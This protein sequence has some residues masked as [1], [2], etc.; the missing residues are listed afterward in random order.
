MP[1]TRPSPIPPILLSCGTLHH[2]QHSAL[3]GKR[4]DMQERDWVLPSQ[5]AYDGNR[6]WSLPNNLSTNIEQPVKQNEQLFD[7]NNNAKRQKSRSRYLC[8]AP[9]FKPMTTSEACAENSDHQHSLVLCAY[10]H[11]AKTTQPPAS[12]SMLQTPETAPSSSNIE[13]IFDAALKSYNKKTKKDIK[14]HD[15][16]KQLETCDSP[17]SILSVF[18]AA[19]F[20][21]GSD[22]RLRK[23]LVPTINVLC[24]F[25][26][27]LGEGV[28]SPAKV[29]FAG[30]GVLLLAAKDVVATQ[31]TLIDTFGRIESFFVRLEIY[32]GVPLTQ[33][34]TDKMVQITVEV[35]DILATA[36]KEMEQSRAKGGGE[37]GS[38]GWAEEALK[39]DR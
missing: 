23:W 6:L 13:R 18:Q 15:L 31:D 7:N 5:D 22:D 29:V 25:S 19:Q 1:T 14:N 8:P 10:S 9:P 38:G 35:L 4:A 20:E 34:M 21:A 2:R 30:A 16:F 39:T 27:A 26:D 17:A 37:D 36:T 33:A 24:A 12:V 28:F 11:S 3:L 32:T